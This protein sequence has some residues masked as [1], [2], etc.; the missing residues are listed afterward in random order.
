MISLQSRLGSER[1][2]ACA[3]VSS[4]ASASCG[5]NEG[6]TPID[7]RID[8]SRGSG[9]C[10]PTQCATSELGNSHPTLIVKGTNR[11]REVQRPTLTRPC[12]RCTLLFIS[13]I[14]PSR[15]RGRSH[16]T[17]CARIIFAAYAQRRREKLAALRRAYRDE[18]IRR[19]RSSLLALEGTVLEQTPRHSA[20]CPP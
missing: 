3:A 9:A 12:A 2:N 5:H 16:C 1:S 11:E 8:A 20:R 13:R 17:S 4:D 10:V 18:Q 7:T 15:S 6:T 14:T 19:E